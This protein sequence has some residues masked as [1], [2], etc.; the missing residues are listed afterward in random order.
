MS[1]KTTRQRAVYGVIYVWLLLLTPNIC[2]ADASS[3][4]AVEQIEAAAYDYVVK[5]LSRQESSFS[6][7][8]IKV[9]PLDPR[10]SLPLCNDPPVADSKGSTRLA[11]SIVVQVSCVNPSTWRIHV[12]VTVRL[13]KEVVVAADGVQRQTLLTASHLMLSE[14]EV[15]KLRHNYLSSS[16]DAIGKTLKR[17]VSQDT[18]IS[19]GMLQEHNLI[20]R[21]DSVMIVATKKGLSVRMPGVA[22][23]NGT[24][25]SQIKVKNEHSQRIVRGKITAAGEIQVPM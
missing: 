12:P 4:R 23:M 8:D 7:V 9:S 3:E 25:G 17:S 6:R 13:Y 20:K 10:L 22:L 18:V 16:A 15:S 5:A 2:N 19:H 1:T 24:L 21:G 11:G 14:R